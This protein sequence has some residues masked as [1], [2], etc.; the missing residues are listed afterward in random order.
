MTTISLSKEQF[1]KLA[2]MTYIGNWVMNASKL[3]TDKDYDKEADNVLHYLSTFARE[4]NMDKY[5]KDFEEHGLDW[6]IDFDNLCH[7]YI[8]PYK[9]DNMF[10]ELA[11]GLTYRDFEKKF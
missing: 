6:T 4:N 11:E 1:K 9:I 3:H 2:I 10:D 8:D 5:V 7:E